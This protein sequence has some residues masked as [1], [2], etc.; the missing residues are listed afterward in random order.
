MDSLA[1][2]DKPPDAKKLAPVFVLYGDED[3]LKRQVLITLRKAVFGS[4]ENGFGL[5]TQSGDRADLATVRGEP[6][7]VS[8]LSQ[9]P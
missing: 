6:E 8:I 1:F 4:E 9:R 2:I 3:F 5:S 7:T